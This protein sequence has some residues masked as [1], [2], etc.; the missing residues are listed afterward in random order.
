MQLLPEEIRL[1]CQEDLR[2]FNLSEIET[3]RLGLFRC[4]HERV[5]V[6]RDGVAEV[7]CVV[8]DL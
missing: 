1:E 6:R 4:R 2:A 3:L 8:D 5:R 7:L